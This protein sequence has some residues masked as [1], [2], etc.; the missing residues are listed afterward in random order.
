MT[1]TTYH[2]P[3][4]LFPEP[5][6]RAELPIVA[7]PTLDV[8]QGKLLGI[9]Q[10]VVPVF[11][12]LGSL[13]FLFAFP[14]VPV[15]IKAIMLVVSLVSVVSAAVMRVVQN[16]SNRSRKSQESRRY[17]EYLA[18]QERQLCSDT[19]A[20]RAWYQ[21]LFPDTDTLWYLGSQR[22]HIWERRRTDQDFT[23]VRIG[24]G[25]QHIS[26]VLKFDLG[27]NPLANYDPV[28]LTAAQHMLSRFQA[29]PDLPLTISLQKLGSLAIVGPSFAR[30]ALTRSIIG[31]L[32]TFH[33]PSDLLLLVGTSPQSHH[34]WSM[35]KWL[36]HIQQESG[37][38]IPYPRITDDPQT[39]S[40]LINE[41]VQ[42]RSSR[43]QQR[44][45]NAPPQPEPG[46]PHVL[47]IIDDYAPTS[48]MGRLLAVE[49]LL[50]SGSQINM[51]LIVLVDSVANEPSNIAAHLIL[52][53]GKATFE[54]SSPTGVRHRSFAHDA[55]NADVF[56][57]ICRTLSPLRVDTSSTEK[58]A[59][60]TTLRLFDLLHVEAPSSIDPHATWA[61]RSL[62]D[63]LRVPIGVR[64]DGEP[65]IIDFKEAAVGGMGPHGLVVGATGSGKS[66]LLRSLIT[67]L[68]VMHSPDIVAFV[69]VDFK[70]GAAFADLANLPH[71]AGMIT[72]L[73]DD[74]S[75]VDRMY[76]A[77]I[78]EQQRRQQLLRMAGNVDGIKEYHAARAKNPNLPPMPYLFIVVDEFAELLAQRPDFLDLF[79]AIGRIGRSIGMSL[80]F[81][82]QRLEEGRLRGLEG[83]LRYRIC[84]RTFSAQE[85]MAVLGTPDAYNLPASPGNGYF[86]VDNQYT[87]FK[88][89]IVT[90][91]DVLQQQ[92][93]S[94]HATVAPF[95]ES[96]PASSSRSQGG[97]TTQISTERTE[98]E[99]AIDMLRMHGEGLFHPP[100]QVW[101]P[102]LPAALPLAS[103]LPP[104]EALSQFP[105]LSVSVGIVDIPLRQMQQ[106]LVLDFSGVNG[107]FAVVGAPQTGKSTFLRTLISSFALTRSPQEVQFSCIDLGGGVLRSCEAL[108][109]V[110]TVCGK[111][112]HETML[113]LI[114]EV[115]LLIE[116]RELLFRE[117]GVANVRELARARPDAA[118]SLA[119]T[120][121]VIDN[122]AQLRQEI[123][124]I[125]TIIAPIL[126]G[127]LGYGVHVILSS[128][129]WNDIR[130]NL[131]DAIANRIEFR[132]NDPTESE[133]DRKVAPR[134]PLSTPG[135]VLLPSK[136][137]G[138]IALPRLDSDT[139]EELAQE[140]WNALV[141]QAQK[142]WA[143]VSPAQKVRLLPTLLPLQDLPAPQEATPQ[144]GILLGVEESR[145]APISYNL[146]EGGQS[147]LVF[148]DSECGKS[149]FLRLLLTQYMATHTPNDVQFAVVDYRRSLLDI[150]DGP[151]ITQYLANAAM[152]KDGIE[153]VRQ[154]LQDRLPPATITRDQLV[155]RSW[156]AG[157]EY[158]ILV[159]DYDLVAT[160]TGN[161]LSPLLDFLPQSRDVG[162]H[163]VLARR[164]AGLSRSSFEQFLQRLRELGTSGFIMS[165][166]PHEGIVLGSQKAQPLPPGRGFLVRRRDRTTLVQTAFVPPN[167]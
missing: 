129:R 44:D 41:I 46:E 98:M 34:E 5:P 57:L 91:A 68:A 95:A 38:A 111:F 14:S 27:S 100:H 71:V 80:L 8:Q 81:A 15:A 69:F 155:H 151:F 75:R 101:L 79:I 115:E 73:Q 92:T 121:L 104:K 109:N 166:D 82:T 114:R 59:L 2:R 107:H 130:S 127:G 88:V 54:E 117:A 148:G 137:I 19:D 61:P 11:T 132:L 55:A 42:P 153:S 10:S 97:N 9:M 126:T 72:N 122:W 89:A 90:G 146:L 83:H 108:P 94:T 113:R 25:E 133:I 50:R 158:V 45:S 22:D 154:I 156:W 157:P 23:E 53:G 56:E 17:L 93:I 64:S 118:Q 65:L 12:S 76:E 143:D 159:D 29:I 3:A 124:D 125:D 66:E 139:S 131:R 26:R 28:I 20:M 63:T 162:L 35:M 140:G 74:T 36:P 13:V 21:R 123:E 135:R 58:R 106:P 152:A 52:Q 40:S 6:S 99:T 136:L 161:P 128:G 160:P 112:D 138:Q 105:P 70:G 1:T 102:P 165:G 85:S 167:Q 149:N 33:A 4:R 39:F 110:G 120:F 77:L 30:L 16:R 141:A 145:L 144:Q 87:S 116:E 24:T 103:V 86:K 60:P 51:S 78:G 18:Q 43:L 47:V 37:A 147:L 119:E 163:V 62:E 7:P 31:Q 150:A 49:E 67:S 142:A 32:V 48:A 96:A 164:V 84:L 134:L